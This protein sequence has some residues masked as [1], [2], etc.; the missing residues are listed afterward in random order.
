MEEEEEEEEERTAHSAP[1][2]VSL[3][4]FARCQEDLRGMP[5]STVVLHAHQF[6]ERKGGTSE[7][8]R[9]ELNLKGGGVEGMRVK[10]GGRFNFRHSSGKADREKDGERESVR[11]NKEEDCAGNR[12]ADAACAPPAFISLPPRDKSMD[13]R[14]TSRGFNY[15]C[16]HLIPL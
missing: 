16:T 13:N 7:R 15:S 11:P 3:S 6:L 14:A 1:D 8:E 2:V 12:P 4:D 5:T 10:W 9:L